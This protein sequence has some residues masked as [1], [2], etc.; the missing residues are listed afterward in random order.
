[1][2]R[3]PI[4]GGLVLE[5]ADRLLV[6]IGGVVLQPLLGPLDGVVHLEALGLAAGALDG[7]ARETAIFPRQESRGSSESEA[8]GKKRGRGT[9]EMTVP[10]GLRK[11]GVLEI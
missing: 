3:G 10:P 2:L 7:N 1:M 9:K 8:F 6:D 4:D 5:G 11:K